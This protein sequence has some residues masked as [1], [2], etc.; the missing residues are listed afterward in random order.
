MAA[1]QSPS[2]SM[3]EDLEY[4]V[5]KCTEIIGECAPRKGGEPTC[6]GMECIK[7]SE[8]RARARIVLRKLRGKG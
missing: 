3:E 4:I 1:Y 8:I 5:T 2:L 7:A 6:R